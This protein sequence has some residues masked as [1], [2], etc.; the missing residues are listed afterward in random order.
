MVLVCDYRL[1]GPSPL[2][3]ASHMIL[4]ET[5]LLVSVV[6]LNHWPQALP[7]HHR[8]VSIQFSSC[9]APD[10]LSCVLREGRQCA[11]GDHA[12]MQPPV[13]QYTQTSPS[14]RRPTSRVLLGRWSQVQYWR[15]DG[16]GR[17][18]EFP[19]SKAGACM[20]ASGDV[21]GRWCSVGYAH[22]CL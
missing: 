13:H 11:V 15:A 1:I 18:Y 9:A 20:L 16:P 14:Y 8:F 5:C 3:F 7:S 21:S 6:S 10:R 4:A 22:G 17:G 2:L 19:W 12:C